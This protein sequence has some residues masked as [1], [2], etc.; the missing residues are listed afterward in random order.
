MNRHLPTLLSLVLAVALLPGCGDRRPAAARPLTLL[1]AA[2]LQPAVDELLPAF[3]AESGIA[4]V[5]DYAGSGMILARASADTAADLFLPGDSF[6]VDALQKTA[7]RVA[8]RTDIAFLVP[9]IIV[10]KGNPKQVLSLQDF[11]R[12][13]LQVARGRPEACQ[14]G[15]VTVALLEKAGVAPEG[16][17]AKESLTVNEL[18]LWVK[19]GDVDAAV[20][21][22]A[23]AAA[24]GEAVDTVPIPPDP[25]CVSR[26]TL[27]RLTS[28]GDVDA[29]RQFMRFCTGPHGRDILRRAGFRVEPPGGLPPL[30]TS[31]REGA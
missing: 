8:E 3:A 5:P 26:V 4:M 9:C 23:T 11:A 31:Q 13:G 6:Y 10:A 28:A 27:A 16:L 12:A 30:R 15:R 22:D 7:G 29:A 24:L 20:V 1:C 21:W 19:I 17:N 14:I 18:A 25:T 2:G